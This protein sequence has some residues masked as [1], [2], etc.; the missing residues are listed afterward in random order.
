MATFTG[1]AA[2]ETI[3]PTTV[4]A[5]VTRVPAGSFPSDAPIP[6][7][8]ARAMTR[9]MAA[10][11]TTPSYGRGGERL[12]IHVD[13]VGDLEQDRRGRWPDRW[14]RRRRLTYSGD[15]RNDQNSM[16]ATAS[17]TDRV[18]TNYGYSDYA[19]HSRLARRALADDTS[20]GGIGA[21]DVI[22]GGDGNDTIGDDYY[23]CRSTLRQVTAK[24]STVARATIRY[25]LTTSSG[26]SSNERMVRGRRGYDVFGVS[27]ADD[28]VVEYR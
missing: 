18:E 5:T 28:E 16:V 23:Y 25:C 6:F 22:Y 15:E 26:F 3:T 14:W 24:S 10:E 17:D 2:N 1:T 12:A 7:S 20:F 27:F 11:V 8:R 13:N 19:G 9:S 21:D 4:S